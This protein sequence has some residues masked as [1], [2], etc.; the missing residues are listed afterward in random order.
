MQNCAKVR[1]DQRV[2]KS[3]YAHMQNMLMALQG[4]H[5]AL[6]WFFVRKLICPVLK[7]TGLKQK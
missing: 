6:T 1:S 3:M 7:K 5:K 2:D 4:S